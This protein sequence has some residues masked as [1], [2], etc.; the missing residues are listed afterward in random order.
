[1][2]RSEIKALRDKSPEELSDA[3]RALRETM[4]KDRIASAVEGKR[5]GPKYRALRRQIARL[6]T[7][8]GQ[9]SA[10]GHPAEAG[11][12]PA[13]GQ[14]DAP[15]A[16]PKSAKKARAKKPAAEKAKA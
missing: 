16:A 10:A 8:I 5:L 11:K 4:L 6:S 1:M 7:I 14:Y 12:A 3:V 13:P 15:A 2:K 9:K